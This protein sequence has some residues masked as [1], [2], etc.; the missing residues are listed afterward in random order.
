MKVLFLLIFMG[1]ALGCERTQTITYQDTSSFF[2]HACGFLGTR[3]LTHASLDLFYYDLYACYPLGEDEPSL[4]EHRKAHIRYLEHLY[5]QAY[6][7]AMAKLPSSRRQVIEYNEFEW[8]QGCKIFGQTTPR[9]N[10]ICVDGDEQYLRFLRNR[11]YYW[12]TTPERRTLIDK[13]NRLTVSYEYENLSFRDGE[14]QRETPVDVEDPSKGT[15]VE[16]LATLLPD[17]CHQATIGRD[18]YLIGLLLPTNDVASEPATVGFERVL[19][20]WKN[21]DLHAAHQLPLGC[22]VLSVAPHGSEVTVTFVQWGEDELYGL[23][24]DW[25]TRKRRTLTLDISLDTYYAVRFTNWYNQFKREQD[26]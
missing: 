24:L 5:R 20:I 14:L 25:R 19:C 13:M 21:G 6:G 12:E 1:V 9:P 15:Y 23:N 22:T 3:A 8:R 26:N 17:F 2:R 7:R 10:W 4:Q 11:V 18:D 16:C